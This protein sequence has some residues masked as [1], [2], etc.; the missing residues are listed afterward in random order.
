MKPRRNL[1]LGTLVVIALSQAAIAETGTWSGTATATWDTSDANWS[2]LT[3]T[4]PWDATNGPSNTAIFNTASLAAT[5]SGTVHTNGITFTLGGS[6]NGASSAI[7]LA[8]TNP[9]INVAASQTAA[10]GTTDLAGSAGLIK[11]G[12]GILS[13]GSAKTLTGGVTVNAGSLLFT[14]GGGVGGNAINLGDTSGTTAATLAWANNSTTTSGSAVT[15]R[16]GSGGVKTLQVNSG[17]TGTISSLALNDNVTKIN[18]G[19]LNVTN[20]TVLAVGDRTITVNAGTLSLNGPVDESAAS[21]NLIKAGG[22]TLVL[23]NATNTFTGTTSVTGGTLQANAPGSLPGYATLGNVTINGGTLS[24][25]VGGSGWSTIQVDDLLAKT[26]KT[27]GNFAID[28]TNGN[29]TQW[30]ALTPTNLGTLGLVKNGTNR[31]TLD[32]A[33]SFTGGV[34]V[35]AGTL[36]LSHSNALG[37]NSKNLDSRGG[38]RVVEL[39]GGITIGSNISWLMSS[40]SGDGGGLSNIDGDNQILGNITYS[41]GNPAFNISSSGTGSL[42]ILGNISYSSGTSGRVLFLGG[43]STNPS[44]IGGNITEAGG[45]SVGMPL[46][47]QGAGTWV[48]SGANSYTGLT[49]VSAGTL[50]AQNNTA[51]GTTAAGTTVNTPTVDGGT[52]DLGGTLALNAF[53]LPAE[54]ITIHGTGVG[55]NGALVNNGSNDQ[56]NAVEQLVLG[57]NATIGGT[58]RWDVRGTGTTFNMAGKTLTKTGTNFIAFVGASPGGVS[59]TNPGN[60]IVNQ[61]EL[62]VHYGSTFGI[63]GATNSITVN[64]GGTFSFYQSSPLHA[65]TLNLNNGSTLRALSGSGAQNTWAGPIN[66]AGEVNLFA[67]AVLTVSNTVSGTANLTK[68]GGSTATI[69]GNLTHTGNLTANAGTLVLSGTNSYTGTTNVNASTLSIDCTNN[70]SKLPDGSALNL[71]GATVN[72]S[73]GAFTEAVGSVNLT[74]G[75]S[76]ITQAV[77]ATAVLQM[78]TITPSTGAS[79]NFG[80]DGIASTDN[81]NTG[82]ILGPWATVGGTTWA[83]NSTGLDNGPIT[84]LTTYTLT[85]LAGDT[86]SN[87]AGANI[88]ID[89]NQTLDAAATPNSL[90]FNNAAA[91]TLTLTGTNTIGSGGVLVTS[92]VGNNL[93]T[94]EVGS[95]TGP[96]N[97]DFVINQQNTANSLLITS[98]IVNNGTTNVVKLGPGRAILSGDNSYSGTTIIGAGPLQIDNAASLG[99]STAISVSGVSNSALVL[100]TDLTAGLGKTVTIRGGGLEGLYGGISTTSTNLAAKWEG[101]VVIGDLPNTRIGSRAGSLEISGIISEATPGSGVIV[102]SALNDTTVIFSGNNTFSGPLSINN[103]GTLTIRHANALGTTAGGT[104]IGNNTTLMF[105]GGIT[106]AAEPLNLTGGGFSDV[107]ALRNFSGDNTCTGPITLAAQSRIS[108]S[109]DTLTLDVA[110]GPAIT[111]TNQSVIFSGDGNIVV[112]DPITTGTGAVTKQGIGTLNL[113]AENTYTG[114]TSFQGGIV[115]VPSLTD[116]G[117]AGPLGARTAAQEA[118]TNIGLRFVGGTLQYT[119]S[120]AQSTN[121]QIRIGIAGGAID[122]S[123]STPTATLSFTH[124]GA[125]TDLYDTAG[126]RTL[127]LTGT[128]AGDNTFA[129]KLEDQAANPTSLTKTGIGKWLLTN[130]HTYTGNTSVDEGT[131]VIASSGSLRFKPTTSGTSNKLTGSGSGTVNFDGTLSIDLSTAD[132]TPGNL[133]TLVDVPSL[134]AVNYGGGFAVTSTTLG[135]FTETSAGVWQITVGPNAWTFTESSGEL[136]Y[137]PL[138]DDYTSWA[139]G[140]SPAVGAKTADDDGDGLTNFEEY[141][142]GLN[143][144]S[145]SSA[146]PISQ[147]LNKTSG[148]FKYTRRATP[149]STGV[150]YTYESSTTLSGAWNPVTPAS[151]VSNNASPVE[152]ITVTLPGTPLADPKFFIRVKAVK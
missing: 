100:G 78:N 152:E 59:I 7:T 130:T 149:G 76:S 67:E 101:N 85:S 115:N 53:N 74:S 141:A 122:A 45:S 57:A 28:T 70:T 84:G 108:S 20:N 109:A 86:A 8:G 92:T 21:A 140:F 23:A 58:K 47:K 42:T 146:N 16:S 40:N 94:I 66:A 82:G 111:G 2:G 102:R 133:W 136:T 89:S 113:N 72:L 128:N 62:N 39:S 60:V 107:G 148:Q 30:T 132:T 126:S 33:N 135:A 22:G 96:A 26:T 25:R 112:S 117:V 4:P 151:E 110:S 91:N 129:I 77:G 124:S 63:A 15:V 9:F 116:Y 119:G 137:G 93:S 50:I 13:L 3:I 87:Y 41:F 38:S 11:T 37:T 144:L 51:L 12:D 29:L 138:G 49:T 134:T 73:A 17:V 43:S 88:S 18:D 139:S 104:T 145:G 36:R 150:T 46:T 55:G 97:G 44:R 34:A 120:T 31:L 27:S 98:D 147:P 121:R 65:S 71:S 142:I 123:G 64:N 106:F 35:G 99:A 1:F 24:V 131:L 19:T 54:V 5:V 68:T 118:A 143:P 14:T 81:S 127:T 90:R 83:V 32:Q 52:L 95:I 79:I 48:L 69:S 114:V 56:T 80:A 125:N 10:I 103:N 75:A 105:E 6:L 61:G